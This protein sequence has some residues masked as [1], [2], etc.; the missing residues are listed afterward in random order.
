[1]LALY[2]F[3]TEEEVVTAANNTSVSDTTQCQV[4]ANRI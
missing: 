4:F 3:D 1:V 2:S